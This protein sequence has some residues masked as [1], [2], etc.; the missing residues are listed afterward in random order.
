MIR[1]LGFLAGLN[2]V[3]LSP[4]EVIP[5]LA[6][7][8]YQGISWPLAWFDPRKKS[9]QD[10]KKLITEGE[11][12]GLQVTEWV[13]QVDY[14]T[15]DKNTWTD[16]IKH[17]VE[18]I[19]AIG[20]SGSKAPINLFTGPAPWDP[21]A[22]RLTNDISEGAAWDLVFNAFDEFITVAEKENVV[23]A[24]EPVFGHLV[25]DYYTLMELFRKFNSPNLRV[26]F[27]PSHG[28]L[29]QND[30]GWVIK[31]LGDKIVH[32]HLKDAVGRP[33]G[34]PGETFQF[35]LLGEGEVPWNEF[36]ISLDEIGYSGFLTVEFESFNYYR[37]VLKSD[38]RLAARQ[39]MH[40][41]KQLGLLNN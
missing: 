17:T 34:L 4:E 26:N 14:V 40:D 35:P 3:D 21:T 16:R 41:V 23:L 24:V 30:T 28:I 2:L 9:D 15:L 22:P 19:Q 31:Q 8:G 29:Y 25:H 7:E 39:A 12:D 36:K 38:P 20:R 10:R 11:K 33:G 27:D 5:I 37:Q 1:R 13:A 32:C 18:I 6:Q